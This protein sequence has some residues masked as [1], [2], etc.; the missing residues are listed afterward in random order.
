MESVSGSSEYNAELE[1]VSD[2]HESDEDDDEETDFSFKI[3]HRV[4]TLEKKLFRSTKV[5]S[6]W[7]ILFRVRPPTTSSKT[8][9]RN[10][11]KALS[12]LDVRSGEPFL[13]GKIK[14]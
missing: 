5:N 9:I 12:A 2:E 11:M 1:S 10:P 8:R 6:D 4:R 13:S 7:E 14:F 3:E